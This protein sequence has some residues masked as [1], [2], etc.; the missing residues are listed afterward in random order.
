MV[1]TVIPEAQG[2]NRHEWLAFDSIV[3]DALATRPE[4]IRRRLRLFLHVMEWLPVLRYRRRF[5]GLDADGRVR[6]L[7]E[8]QDHRLR[9]IRVGFWGV[10]SLALMGYYGRADAADA[11]GYLPHPRGREAPRSP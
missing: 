6:A 9:V 11:I 1:R 2:L 3:A 8:L 7:R 10:R 4:H 5:T